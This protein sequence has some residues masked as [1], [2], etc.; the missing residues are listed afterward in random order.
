MLVAHGQEPPTLFVHTP[1][2]EPYQH[3]VNA[4][5]V[6]SYGEL[7]PAAFATVTFPF[8]FG[9]MYGDVGH[10]T[11]LVLMALVLIGA[12]KALGAR[13]LDEITAMLFAAR[14]M[15]LAMGCF[16]IYCGV[17]YSDAFGLPF[18]LFA[19]RWA[20]PKSDNGVRVVFFFK[21]FVHCIL[22]LIESF[23]LR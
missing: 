16:S 15:I 23:C 18:P 20:M 17:L 21:I 4:Y 9:V 11:M 1:H 6:P 5:G 12:Q 10:G 8:L 13:K 3:L 22:R 2:T 14:W 7:N 19:S